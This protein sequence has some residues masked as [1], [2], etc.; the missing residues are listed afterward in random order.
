[1]ATQRRRKADHIPTPPRPTS[2]SEEI[3][4][5]AYELFLARGGAHGHDLEDWFQAERE[6]AWEVQ[7]L[8]IRRAS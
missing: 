5:R 7:R 1:M 3:A 2:S 8:E 4:R 6:L